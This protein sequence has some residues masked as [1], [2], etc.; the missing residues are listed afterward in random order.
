MRNRTSLAAAAAL[1][2]TP[3]AGNAQTPT[4]AS[5]GP[6][7]LEATRQFD[8][9]SA[10]NG[11]NYRVQVS[12]P[13]APPPPR[14]FPVLY[15][16]DGNRLFGSF[17]GAARNRGQ[18]GE[19]EN[20]VV[21]G[22]A[23]GEGPH[24]ANRTLDFTTYDMTVREKV[25]IKDQEKNAPFGGSERFLRAIQEEIKPRVARLAP[26]D[27]GRSMLFGW[28]LGGLFVVHTMLS[29][30]GTFSTYLALSPALWRSGRAVFREV[31][32][33]KRSVAAASVKPR[34]YLGVSELEG[35]PNTRP[36]PDW[37]A[38]DWAN[39]INYCRMVG[40]MVDMADVLRG[41]MQSR[42]LAFATRIFPGETHNSVP[43]SALN[44]VLT[45]ALGTERSSR[46]GAA[47]VDGSYMPGP[48]P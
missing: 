44:P 40:N 17:A 15:V 32:G 29:H 12:I 46:G 14:G 34:L 21:V 3:L 19:I 2:L 8:V 37:T 25:V 48:H 20:A 38:E 22:I 10:I 6:A 45:F 23:S 1:A 31:P 13:D 27:E 42:H 41:F 47:R 30:P 9:S 5:A 4:A 26:V 33:F 7:T 36:F 43:W 11:E 16:L 39:E 35:D 28:S 18:A 24:G